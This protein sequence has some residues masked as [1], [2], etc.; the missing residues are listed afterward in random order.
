MML[1]QTS[2]ADYEELC[3]L[4]VLG[5]SDSS[6]HDHAVS[7]L[8]RIQRTT[9]AS[10]KRGDTKPYYHGQCSHQATPLQDSHKKKR[11][12]SLI[13]MHCTHLGAQGC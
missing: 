6:E 12:G 4:D 7:C 1:T 2:H 5:L 9:G 11:N 3:R 8:P 10:T 13:G